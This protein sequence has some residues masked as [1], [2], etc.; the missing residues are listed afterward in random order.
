M[1]YYKFYDSDFLVKVIDCYYKKTYLKKNEEIAND[2]ILKQF[3]EM[4][5]KG[6][7]K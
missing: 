5:K 3:D 2:D 7:Q 6:T 4:F 1:D